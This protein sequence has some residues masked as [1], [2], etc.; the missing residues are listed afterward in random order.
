MD[1]GPPELEKRYRRFLEGRGD[2]VAPLL[3]FIG[4]DGEARAGSGAWAA[5]IVSRIF[6]LKGNLPLA[7]AYL[8]LAA[9]LAGTAGGAEPQGEARDA[10]LRL[11]I[12]VN[13][14]LILKAQ[15]KTRQAAELLRPVVDRALREGETF[16]AAKAA[17]NLA[18]CMARCG[19]AKSA[20]SYL[21]LAERGYCAAGCE[22][23]LIR[24]SM[25]RALV[26]AKSGLHDEAVE[27]ICL[28]LGKCSKERFT[29]E[30]A[31]GLL[32]LAELL[33]AKENL[34]A[35]RE[36][37][38]KAASMAETLARFGPQRLTWIRLER[39]LSRRSGGAY[40][41]LDRGGSVAASVVREAA[42]RR[43]EAP[44]DSS[45]TFVTCDPRMAGILEEI[46]RAAGLPLPLLIEGESGTGK[47]L[48]ARLVHFWS[49]REREPF[50]PVNVAALP[51]DLFESLAFGHAR[52][53]FTGAVEN[54]PGLAAAAGRGTL[55]LD[56][57]GELSPAVQAKLLRLIDRR[58]YIP[59]GETRPRRFEA[60]VVAATNRD[61]KA[62]CASGRLRA[63]LYYRL[64]PL[65]FRIPP[66][67]ERPA[68]IARLARHFADRLRA[69]YGIGPASLH[70]SALIALARHAWPG[71]ARELESEILR[72]ALAAKGGAIRACH[73][74]PAVMMSLAGNA[75]PE[76]N[77]LAAKV[78]AI[79]RDEII[80]ALH[81]CG[82]NRT[83]AARR[84]G[85]KRT[86][87]LSSMRRLGIEY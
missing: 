77:D 87:L 84:L 62:D 56:E 13:R 51:A 32:L 30:R 78:N 16:V 28:A 47:D 4:S 76:G 6:L 44:G 80:A 5:H 2:A 46:R 33:L 9:A 17:A 57:I 82:G 43:V 10:T 41:T 22:T 66:L 49:G 83:N 86:T 42:P 67:R 75:P 8:R 14:A 81:A 85:L 48:V 34:V 64:A 63:D 1:P 58:E 71:N 68:D 26:E 38:D 50:V 35:A 19:E 18:L 25:T 15:G 59:L 65:V 3:C 7:H 61:L 29:R 69:L 24:L 70:E 74:S 31:I 52:G 55:F 20:D 73:L 27:R 11:G 37:L 40:E 72:G 60:R 45:E 12:L 53:A 23:G 39:E 54:R 79:E 21:G 36:A